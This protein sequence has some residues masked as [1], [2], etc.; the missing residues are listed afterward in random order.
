MNFIQK[1]VD[2]ASEFT[3]APKII[4]YRTALMLISSTIQR[5]LYLVQGHKWIYPNL[6]ML[7]IAPSSFYRKS[8]SISIAEDIIREIDPTI[9]MPNEFSREKIVEMMQRQPTGLFTMYEFSNF[10]GMCSRDYMAG[11]VSMI[12]E[13]FDSPLEYRREIKEKTYIIERPFL[14]ILGA[15]TI[16]WLEATIKEKEITGGFLPRFLIV[17]APRK[18][19]IVAFQPESD[20]VKRAELVSILKEYALL[21]GKMWFNS[22]A[23]AFYEKWYI[24]YENYYG[25]DEVMLTGFYTRLTEYA[26]KFAILLNIDAG[27]G[28]EI[29]EDIVRDS[30]SMAKGFAEETKDLILHGFSIS[31]FDSER[32]KVENIIKKNKKISRSDLLRKS[33]ISSFELSRIIQTLIESEKIEENKQEFVN[34]QGAGREISSY[35]WLHNED[36]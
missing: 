15:S 26:K 14:N 13:L 20:K 19:K 5:N 28:M 21:S 17:T 29:G 34:V 8:Y 33:K 2:Y 7:I 6:F 16:D 10:M 23:I 22:K 9:L 4:H 32:N 18:D 27:K 25:H 30:C 11:T 24:D 12:T 36:N 1:Y 31:K 35:Q 3:D